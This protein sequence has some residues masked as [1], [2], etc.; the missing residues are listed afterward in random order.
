MA[1]KTLEL[2]EEVTQ[3]IIPIELA[4]LHNPLFLAGTNHKNKL[5]SNLTTQIQLRFNLTSKQLYVLFKGKIALIPE[6]NIASLTPF[7][8]DL[9][10]G[11]FE[12]TPVELKPQRSTHTHH[13]MKLDIENRAQVST[14]TSTVQNPGI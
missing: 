8:T 10:M 5:V 9:F 13:A 6:S 11:A 7:D 3:T 12:Q 2:V 14:P 4:E 1:K